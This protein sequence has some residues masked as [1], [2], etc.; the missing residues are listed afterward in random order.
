MADIVFPMIPLNCTNK[1]YSSNMTQHVKIYF[2]LKTLDTAHSEE[3]KCK[4]K[5]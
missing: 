5:T 3:R 1:K 4:F 2:G